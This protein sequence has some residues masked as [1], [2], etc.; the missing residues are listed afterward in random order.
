MEL[1]GGRERRAIVVVPYDESWP[2]AFA[3]ERDRILPALGELAHRVDH[4]GSTAVAGLPAKPI[5]DIDVSVDDPDDER[6]YVPLLRRAGYRLRV[7]EPGH[8]MLRTPALDVHLHVCATGGHWERTHLLFR[9]W[10][11]VAGDDR[12]RYAGVKR[13]L[14][15]RA[16]PDMNAYSAAKAEVIGEIT[17]RAERWAASICWSPVRSSKISQWPIGY[18]GQAERSAADEPL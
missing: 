9:D 15:Q 17:Q 8:R 1:I 2:G 13:E 10:L 11:R 4:I 14:A 6:L 7:R 16:W 18:R 3:R 12:E 5:I